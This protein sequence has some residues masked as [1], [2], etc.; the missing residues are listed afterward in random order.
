MIEKILDVNIPLS[1]V[2]FLF[3]LYPKEV[4]LKKKDYIFINL[5]ILQAKRLISLN[6]K[7]I[8]APSIGYWLKEM[9]TNMSME[10]ITYILRNKT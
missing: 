3:H 6:W 9:V 8:C 4:K 2:L 10:K 7:S 5:G 1:P